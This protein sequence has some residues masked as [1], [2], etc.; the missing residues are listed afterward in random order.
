M[1]SLRSKNNREVEV[2]AG[3]GM[4]E[5]LF[6]LFVITFGTLGLFNL[7]TNVLSASI[8]NQT[9]TIAIHLAEE[10]L[11]KVMH[12]RVVQGYDWVDN[13]RYT[14]PESITLNGVAYVRTTNIY[15]VSRTDL[16]TPQANS[17][18]KRVDITVTSPVVPQVIPLSTLLG[19]Y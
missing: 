18:V 12:D 17:R 8:Q 14:S 3:F 10:Q 15:E 5:A 13:S 1:M 7:F 11:E 9:T 2:C 4:M 19:K 6:T 16:I